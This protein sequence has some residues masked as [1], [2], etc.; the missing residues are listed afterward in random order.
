[1][2]VL[3][4]SRKHR[5]RTK[6]TE[7][8]CATFPPVQTISKALNESSASMMAVD[9]ENSWSNQWWRRGVCNGMRDM[10][11]IICVHVCAGAGGG[12]LCWLHLC[13]ADRLVWREEPA[14]LHYLP[15][16]GEPWLEQRGML[17][18]SEFSKL[19]PYT[20]PNYF[21]NW[22]AGAA[23]TS[24]EGPLFRQQFKALQA[25]SWGGG[26]YRRCVYTNDKS[27]LLLFV[28]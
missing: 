16:Q 6:W 17:R 8:Q 4:K 3:I 2:D 7:E 24:L 13:D 10:G 9:E 26:F 25:L 27:V 15:Q 11:W 14:C 22:D 1:M 19:W 20:D 5:N 28:G 23:L 12:C 21:S 18:L